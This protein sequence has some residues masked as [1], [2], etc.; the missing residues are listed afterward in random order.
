[1][2]QTAPSL[3]D[4]SKLE[5]PR[6]AR[7]RALLA[8]VHAGLGC[9]QRGGDGL[10]KEYEVLAPLTLSVFADRHEIGPF[11]LLGG[12]AGRVGRLRITR[13]GKTRQEPAKGS[14]RLE[15]EDV[16]SIETP[17]DNANRR[18]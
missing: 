5:Q 4:R 13:R 6:Q 2:A 3:C 16:V 11:G 12:K 1:M 7:R 10:V 18:V 15:P 17:P 14:H 8:D 9:D